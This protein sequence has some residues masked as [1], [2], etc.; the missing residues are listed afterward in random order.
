VISRDPRR[1][2]QLARLMRGTGLGAPVSAAQL[3]ALSDRIAAA[4]APL[5]AEREVR[6]R[7][8]WDYAASWSGILLPA[9]VVTALAASLC[10]F[11]LSV[12]R[13]PPAPKLSRS[14]IA[15]IGAA[16]NRVSSQSLVDFLVTSDPVTS[17]GSAR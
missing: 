16:T 9:G 17:R 14:R 10:L 5:L 1:D 3:R 15:L 8:V 12:Q 4:A 2:E 13:E 11:M 6:Q 7:T